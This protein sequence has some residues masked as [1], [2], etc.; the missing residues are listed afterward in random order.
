MFDLSFSFT[1]S[2]LFH[3]LSVDFFINAFIAFQFVNAHCGFFSNPLL[4]LL[5]EIIDGFSGF[6]AMIAGSY[7]AAAEAPPGMLAS[8]NGILFAA[9]LAVGAYFH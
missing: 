6:T 3:N 1:Y 2:K 8:F 5:T 9:I 4:L 7:Y